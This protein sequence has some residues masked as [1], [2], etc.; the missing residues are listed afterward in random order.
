MMLSMSHQALA[1]GMED[2]AQACQKGMGKEEPKALKDAGEK[3]E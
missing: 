3:D 1:Q 2:H